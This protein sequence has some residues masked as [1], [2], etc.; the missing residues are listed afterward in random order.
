[1][2]EDNNNLV[3]K[4]S[5]LQGVINVNSQFIVCLSGVASTHSINGIR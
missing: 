5:M 4:Y 2:S 3:A 1:M